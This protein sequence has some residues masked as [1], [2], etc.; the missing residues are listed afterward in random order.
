M[1]KQNKAH[2]P[3]FHP[4][5]SKKLFPR[6]CKST[7]RGGKTVPVLGPEGPEG[8]PRVG[9]WIQGAHKHQEHVSRLKETELHEIKWQT[10]RVI[11]IDGFE[12]PPTL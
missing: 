1:A 9:L 6:S 11:P 3:H 10:K 2:H 12:L 8:T 5:S 7:I 4:L